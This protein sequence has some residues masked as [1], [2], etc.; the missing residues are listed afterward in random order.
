MYRFIALI[1]LTVPFL[2]LAQPKA[3]SFV[4]I[5]ATP[6]GYGKASPPASVAESGMSYI[7]TT[8]RV[9]GSTSCDVFY[10]ARGPSEFHG[11][12]GNVA[13]GDALRVHSTKLIESE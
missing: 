11:Y 12:I 5:P 3:P 4:V 2:A 9:L 6:L 8:T 7:V 1:L 10:S 13:C